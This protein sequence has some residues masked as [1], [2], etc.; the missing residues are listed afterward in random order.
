MD[1]ECI[2]CSIVDMT[3]SCYSFHYQDLTKIILNESNLA[4]NQ[5]HI[6][7]LL[8]AAHCPP[9][10]YEMENS[11]FRKQYA[12]LKAL[13]SQK[14]LHISAL[15]FK[16]YTRLPSLNA[17]RARFMEVL[18]QWALETARLHF[19]EIK[20]CFVY[21]PRQLWRRHRAKQRPC[22]PAGTHVNRA[23]CGPLTQLNKQTNISLPRRVLSGKPDR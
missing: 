5:F 8:L 10:I 1:S 20:F 23:K 7:P 2:I 12:W 16:L 17:D 9:F 13:R 19:Y 14:Y 4:I 6:L 3:L 11:T 22:R 15:F 21:P 18:D